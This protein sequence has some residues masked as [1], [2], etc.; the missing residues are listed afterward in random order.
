MPR[1]MEKI[2][3]D[4]PTLMQMVSRCLEKHFVN[5]FCAGHPFL[6][7]FLHIAFCCSSRILSNLSPS[8]NKSKC[9]VSHVCSYWW[10]SK[11]AQLC[12]GKLGDMLKKIT[13]VFILQSCSISFKNLLWIY[14]FSDMIHTF[15][16]WSF[17]LICKTLESTNVFKN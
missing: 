17:I 14:K 4:C 1:P 10:K 2:K 3:S 8:E 5:W 6:H 11:M 12:R 13:F 7:S 16:Q 15:I 9:W